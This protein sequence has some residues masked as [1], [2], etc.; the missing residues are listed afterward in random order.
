MDQRGASEVHKAKKI[1][2]KVSAIKDLLFKSRYILTFENFCFCPGDVSGWHPPSNRGRGGQTG[3]GGGG[4]RQGHE[5]DSNGDQ[6]YYPDQP[7]S[8]V[9]IYTHEWGVYTHT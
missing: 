1:K 9:Y 5:R 6:Y 7:G 3:G 8:G 4:G 2:K